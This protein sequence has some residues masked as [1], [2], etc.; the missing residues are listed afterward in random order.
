MNFRFH[1]I[2]VLLYCVT[3]QYKLWRGESLKLLHNIPAKHNISPGYFFQFPSYRRPRPQ[4]TH[5]FSRTSF[6][7]TAPWL[8]VIS[9]DKH[10]V[11]KSCCTGA[12]EGSIQT[13]PDE[14][15]ITSSCQTE[16]PFS[17]LVSIDVASLAFNWGGGESLLH[18]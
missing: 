1:L 6:H 2:P 14:M 16:A 8:D 7:E 5:P 18:C 12:S 10:Y 9:R 3:A 15:R 11:E 13:F 17:C 4:L